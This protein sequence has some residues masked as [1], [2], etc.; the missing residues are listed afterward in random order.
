MNDIFISYASEDRE[1]VRPLAEALSR[2]GW[3]VW[4]DRDIST[5]QR[6]HRVIDE[7]LAWQQ[8]EGLWQPRSLADDGVHVG[9]PSGGP[10]AQTQRL[11]ELIVHVLEGKK[12]K[13]GVMLPQ[14][15]A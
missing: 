13:D 3:S 6:F 5:G 15:A 7:E 14:R 12:F 8:N 4:W 1:R 9:P 10:L 11:A 2:Q